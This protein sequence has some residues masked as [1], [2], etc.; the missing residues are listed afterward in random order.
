M[1]S[2]SLLT[3]T[4]KIERGSTSIPLC[5]RIYF[6]RRT[7]SDFVLVLDVH[8]LLLSLVVI[9]VYFQFL[10]MGQIRDPL[11][12]DLVCY[13]LGQVRI[14]VK[15]ES[16]LRDAVGLIVELLGEHLIEVL[17]FLGHEDSGVQLGNAVYREARHDGK[18]RHADLSVVDDAQSLENSSIGHFSRASAMMVWFV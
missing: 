5:S 12:A 16:S 6:A 2:C 10:H 4:S 13:P 3:C 1:Y 18:V 14:A 7:L 17:E 11:V 9:H 15:K 8:E